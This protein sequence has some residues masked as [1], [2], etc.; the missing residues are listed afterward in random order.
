MRTAIHGS[1][2]AAGL[3]FLTLVTLVAPARRP[4]VPTP[5]SRSVSGAGWSAERLSA[6]L[7]GS[8]H[9]FTAGGRF[10]RDLCLPCHTPHVP[11]A[12]RPRLDR[13]AAATQ[14]IRPY[15]TPGVVLNDASLL[16]LSCHDGIIAP[17]VFDG[18]HALGWGELAARSFVPVNRL[19][20]HPIGV[21]YPVNDPRFEPPERVT[22]DGKI[23]LPDGRV[24]CTSCHDPH[25]TGRHEG[26]LRKSNRRSRLCLSCHRI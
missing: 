21:R 13:R 22:G 5:Q 24:Q 23:R 15:Q 20:S 17:D 12:V 10:G 9:D 16:C 4:D 14:P 18:A 8:K 3:I 1:R 11:G 7:V 2:V 26:M 19:T 6:G 25:N